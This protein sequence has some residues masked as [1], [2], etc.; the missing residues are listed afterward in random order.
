MEDSTNH[1]C[2]IASPPTSETN[3]FYTTTQQEWVRLLKSTFQRIMPQITAPILYTVTHWLNTGENDVSHLS[4]KDLENL[5]V[6]AQYLASQKLFSSIVDHYIQEAIE[7]YQQESQRPAPQPVVQPEPEVQEEP[8]LNNTEEEVI[9]YQGVEY[10]PG[11]YDYKRIREQLELNN[12]LRSE[13][14]IIK[15]P[16]HKKDEK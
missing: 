3:A 16:A 5:T 8:T 7:I 13:R 2:S 9:V 4:W 11:H 10:K 14:G 1:P 6:Y 15:N 12:R